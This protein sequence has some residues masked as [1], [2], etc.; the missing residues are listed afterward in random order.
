MDND[1]MTDDDYD[2]LMLKEVHS[3]HI[4]VTQQFN[5]H[6]VCIIPADQSAAI[7]KFI[8]L[9]GRTE[10]MGEGSKR[11]SELRI[12]FSPPLSDEEL[13]EWDS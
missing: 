12:Y 8:K 2:A 3:D 4:I 9:L 6:K 1:I 5:K 13:E 7:S 10:G 11:D